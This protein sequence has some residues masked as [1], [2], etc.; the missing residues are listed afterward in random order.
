[1]PA[2]EQVKTVCVP[3]DLY[4][5]LMAGQ[6][7]VIQKAVESTVISEGVGSQLAWWI[8][9]GVAVAAVILVLKFGAKVLK[10]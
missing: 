4:D 10:V 5:D 8:K 7:W 2:V 6:P 1:M 9:A 3:R